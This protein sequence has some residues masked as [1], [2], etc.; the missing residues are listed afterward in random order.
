M[1]SKTKKK[2]ES[3]SKPVKKTGTKAKKTA[4]KNSA[5]KKKAISGKNAFSGKKAISKKKAVHTKKAAAALA[6]RYKILFISSELHPF[7]KTGGLG[8]VSASLP[9]A[10]KAMYQDIRILIPAYPAA[11]QK[12]ETLK[13]VDR[14]ALPES[15]FPGD[16]GLPEGTR[17]VAIIETRLPSS[18]VKVWMIESELYNRSGGP[19][20]DENAQEWPDNDRRFALLNYVATEIAMGRSGLK[21]QPDIVHGNDWQTGLTS[22]L[23]EQE[24]IHH[25]RQR[26]A[27]VFTIHNM[28]HMGVFSREQFDALQLPA[29]LW[30]HHELEFHDNFSFIKGGLVFSDRVN[31]VS[32]TYARE[33]QTEEF[34]Y[35][36]YGLLAYRNERLS[37][38]LNGIDMKE[39]DP[40]KDPLIK[41]NY[42][43]KTLANKQSNKSALQK[44]FNLPRKKNVLLLGMVAR[45]VYQKGV[46]LL[47]EHMQE[48]LELPVQIVILGSGDLELESRLHQ[49]SYKY[50]E[51]LQVQVGYD[52]AL[53]HLIEAG[54]DAFLMPS[55][56]EPCGLNQ[57]YSLRYGTIP[58]VRKTG[59][60]ADT[61]VHASRENLNQGTATGVVFHEE[62]GSSLYD[63]IN[64]THLLFQD[65]KLWKQLMVTGM[66]QE[67]SWKE[68]A[69]QYLDLY[70]QALEDRDQFKNSDYPTVSE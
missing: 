20:Q 30:N 44:H 70:A 28:A 26:P 38:I 13:Y 62:E 64:L 58:I 29:S 16:L 4:S 25:H 12:A 10:L 35:G 67:F 11:I 1:A 45:L 63:A 18:H 59:G 43:I 19:Y 6:P 47:L 42:S 55:R 2:A 23:L 15:G 53:S 54:S 40:A 65:K 27:T 9:K 49:W 52:E 3:V 50:P 7:A 57:L 5:G 39:W 17:S 46:D 8:D 31:T 48:I 61:V 21:W 69:K 41:N 22:A 34:G 32:P 51:Q 33:I 60:L 68:S 56:F 66:K 14:I 36:L 24:F 37:G